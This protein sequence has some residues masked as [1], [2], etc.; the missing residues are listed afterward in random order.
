MQSCTMS[1]ITYTVPAGTN[2]FYKLSIVNRS[3]FYGYALTLMNIWGPLLYVSGSTFSLDQGSMI[4]NNT[5][6][7]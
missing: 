6:D 5:D 1:N 2:N 7:D 4:S 3:S